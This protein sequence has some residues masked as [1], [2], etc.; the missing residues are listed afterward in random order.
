M[1]QV[2]GQMQ[3]PRGQGTLASPAVMSVA[4]GMDTE[5]SALSTA[6]VLTSSSAKLFLLKEEKKNNNT[7][8]IKQLKIS[9]HFIWLH[10]GYLQMPLDSFPDS[11]AQTPA[12]G[13]G[14]FPSQ[15]L[16][17]ALSP[18]GH[19]HRSCPKQ[20]SSYHTNLLL[21]CP[22]ASANETL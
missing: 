1:L 20:Q 4:L 6:K 16:Y 19:W 11:S 21:Q 9:S 8:L 2:A 17:E 13:T 7:Q 15:L 5:R 14:N 12:K 10:W 18:S 3:C 22:E